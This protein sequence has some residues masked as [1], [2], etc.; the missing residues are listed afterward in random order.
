MDQQHE[1][2]EGKDGVL[3][4]LEARLDAA[5]VD[6][7]HARVDEARAVETGLTTQLDVHASRRNPTP[8]ARAVCF[9]LSDWSEAISGEL[10]HVD[11]GA[12]AVAGVAPAQASSNGAAPQPVGSEAG[13]Q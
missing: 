5:E 12:H 6:L 1:A 10:I 2:P 4:K 11:G 3:E 13:A 9:L 7:E 8:V